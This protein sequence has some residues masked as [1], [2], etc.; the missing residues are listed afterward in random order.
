[1][2]LSAGVTITGTVDRSGN[3]AGGLFG[4]SP[5]EGASQ[6]TQQ[7]Y[8]DKLVQIGWGPGDVL[9][10]HMGDHLGAT[11]SGFVRERIAPLVLGRS[12]DDKPAKESK[13]TRAAKSRTRP[14]RSAEVYR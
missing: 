7:L 8:K 4:F 13:A 14:K 1:V 6:P 10:G 12:P 2:G 5:P 11:R 3:V 9:L